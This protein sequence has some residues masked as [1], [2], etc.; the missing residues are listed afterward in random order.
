M[1]STAYFHAIDGR[2]RL[3]IPGVKGS[4]AKAQ[5]LKDRITGL[6]G[7]SD[8]RPN[9]TTGNVLITYDR[10]KVSQFDILKNLHE[11]GYLK[12]YRTIAAGLEPRPVNSPEWGGAFARVALEVLLT[13]LLV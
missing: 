7:I 1:I 6:P 13:A 11:L 12:D 5:E 4:R 10:Q 9:P 2:M 8:V 3:A